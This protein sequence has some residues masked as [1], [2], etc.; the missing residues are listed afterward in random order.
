MDGTGE[1]NNFGDLSSID[2]DCHDGPATD[3]FTSRGLPFNTDL[4]SAG[5]G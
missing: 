1:A 3:L 2:G 4:Y 5:Q